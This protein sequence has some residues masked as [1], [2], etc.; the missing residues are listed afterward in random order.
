[1]PKDPALA[2][3]DRLAANFRHNLKA[4]RTLRKLSA[5]QVSKRA[6]MHVSALN[7]LQSGRSAPGLR[8]ICRVAVALEVDPLALLA[9]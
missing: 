6:G 8:S 4:I 9:E 2:L 7:D 3:N 1:M 5:A